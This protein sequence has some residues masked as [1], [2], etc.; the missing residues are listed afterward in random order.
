[1]NMEL[2]KQQWT[3]RVFKIAKGHLNLSEI[4]LIVSICQDAF[5]DGHKAGE[6]AATDRLCPDVGFGLTE[7]NYK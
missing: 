2:R 5:N 1:M 7:E 3:N 4:S 6:A